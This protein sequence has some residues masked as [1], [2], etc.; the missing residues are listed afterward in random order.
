MSRRFHISIGAIFLLIRCTYQIS[1]NFSELF[2]FIETYRLDKFPT[3]KVALHMPCLES[4][5]FAT[6]CA[7]HIFCTEPRC[8]RAYQVC[9]KY[10]LRF[11]LINCETEFNCLVIKNIIAYLWNRVQVFKK[12]C[13]VLIPCYFWTDELGSSLF[14]FLLKKCF[15]LNRG[16]AWLSSIR[17]EF[18]FSL[19]STDKL[20]S[21]MSL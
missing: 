2:P 17:C 10:R 6:N 14:V 15:E 12:N 3:G 21:S 1:S 8:K 16:C 11:V 20:Q 5:M 19:K 4:N 18:R 9:E 7:C 13:D